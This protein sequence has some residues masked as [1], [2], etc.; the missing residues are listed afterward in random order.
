M[1][2]QVPVMQF[3]PGRQREDRRGATRPTLCP[4]LPVA[5]DTE[6]YVDYAEIIGFTAAALGTA[7]LFPQVLQS[8]RTKSTGDLNLRTFLAITL[9]VSLFIAYGVAIGSPS[10]ITA[11]SLAGIMVVSLVV[12]K[13]RHG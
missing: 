2:P 5:P 13:L 9:S 7:A 10:V 6:R 3:P 1:E 11:N 12:L 4:T 8:W